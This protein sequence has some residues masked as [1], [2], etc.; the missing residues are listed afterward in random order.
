[1]VKISTRL[2]DGRRCWNG[3][4][5][6]QRRGALAGLA[7]CYSRGASVATPLDGLYMGLLPTVDTS[8]GTKSGCLAFVME[9]D[10]G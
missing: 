7:S 8:G 1:M 2:S 9:W 4:R 3:L 10:G 5:R 6:H